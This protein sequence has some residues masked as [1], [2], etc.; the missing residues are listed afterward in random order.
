MKYCH[1][2]I[3][4]LK[5]NTHRCTCWYFPIT[6]SYERNVTLSN[7]TR[8][9]GVHKLVHLILNVYYI[10]MSAVRECNVSFFYRSYSRNMYTLSVCHAPY[11]SPVVYIH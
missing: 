11:V 1:I 8:Y 5:K 7:N 9:V 2:H 6:A 4:E 10:R 3:R